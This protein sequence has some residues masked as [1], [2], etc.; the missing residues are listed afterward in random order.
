MDAK[1]GGKIPVSSEYRPVHSVQTF[2]EPFEDPATSE[3]LGT[4]PEMGLT[5]TKEAVEA[6][7][8]AFKTWSKTTAK[9]CVFSISMC[10][11]SHK[12]LVTCVG[13]P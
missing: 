5:E 8:V 4:I 6:A 10:R 7:S 1:E 2:I 12:S 11:H 3:E 9:V 13:T